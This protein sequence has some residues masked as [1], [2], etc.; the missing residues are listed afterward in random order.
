VPFPP[1]FSQNRGQLGRLAGDYPRPIRRLFNPKPE[2]Q[3]GNQKNWLRTFGQK[4][5]MTNTANDPTHLK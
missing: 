4:S 2:I 5:L 3:Y 1:H